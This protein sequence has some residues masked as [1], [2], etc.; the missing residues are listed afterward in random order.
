MERSASAV[1]HG[2]RPVSSPFAGQTGTGESASATA[3]KLLDQIG[4]VSSLQRQVGIPDCIYKVQQADWGT[5]ALLL[6]IG[7][8]Q[9]QAL[10]GRSHG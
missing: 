6:L 4:Q 2:T 10:H 7:G 1:H 8:S 9:I 3:A 5:S